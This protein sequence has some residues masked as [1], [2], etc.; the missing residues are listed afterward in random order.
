MVKLKWMAWLIWN[1]IQV[2]LSFKYQILLSFKWNAQCWKV[3]FLNFCKSDH[4]FFS[5]FS[6][7]KDPPFCLLSVFLYSVLLILSDVGK[8][9]YIKVKNKGTTDSSE[10]NSTYCSSRY[11]SSVPQI[12]ILR[13]IIP[14]NSRSRECGSFLSPPWAHGIMY[15]LTD[16]P[17]HIKII[18]KKINLCTSKIN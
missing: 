4:A 15:I 14:C 1:I 11:P 2:L 9:C 6:I 8:F 10:V 12:H 7:S 3:W 5:E 16:R 17:T 13:F 18:L